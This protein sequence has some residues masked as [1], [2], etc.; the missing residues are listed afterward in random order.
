MVLGSTASSHGS[1]A[2]TRVGGASATLMRSRLASRLVR[3]WISC[4]AASGD[5]VR[6]LAMTPLLNDAVALVT[7]YGIGAMPHGNWAVASWPAPPRTPISQKAEPPIAKAV[8][9]AV[10]SGI[11]RYAA[12][13]PG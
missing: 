9:F 7:R 13:G 12:P 8:G 3:Y 11:T 2:S 10:A 1:K 4:Q 5:V 6:W